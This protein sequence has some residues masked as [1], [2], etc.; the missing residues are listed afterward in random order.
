M[1]TGKVADVEEADDDT[2]TYY[3]ETKNGKN[4]QGITAI[5]DCYLYWNGKRLD[6]DDDYALYF[7]D[8]DNIYLVNSKGKVQKTSKKVR[9]RR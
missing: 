6:A 5:K 7:L 4:G 9:F 2:Y 8:E 1:K 3:F